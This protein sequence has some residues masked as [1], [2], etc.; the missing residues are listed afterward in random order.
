MSHDRRRPVSGDM[1]WRPWCRG[2]LRSEGGAHA[3]AERQQPQVVR[4][5]AQPRPLPVITTQLAD[6]PLARLQRGHVP[7][8]CNSTAVWYQP[9]QAVSPYPHPTLSTVMLSA[10]TEPRAGRPRDLR[11]RCSGEANRHRLW[12]HGANLAPITAPQPKHARGMRCVLCTCFCCE[13]W[14]AGLRVTTKLPRPGC[15][16]SALWPTTN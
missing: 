14:M 2:Q 6:H 16:P 11:Q 10:A 12:S 3:A 7:P 1:C 9:C 13:A 5:A 15:G 8:R 4:E